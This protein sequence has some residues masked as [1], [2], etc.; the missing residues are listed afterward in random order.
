MLEQV[1]PKAKISKLYASEADGSTAVP[2][3]CFDP[4]EL[5]QPVDCSQGQLNLLTLKAAN[6]L[7]A[8]VRDLNLRT[9]FGISPQTRVVSVY[10]SGALDDAPSR[11][12]SDFG[13]TELLAHILDFTG[14]DLLLASRALSGAWKVQPQIDSIPVVRLSD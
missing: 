12:R 2:L 10:L 1:F 14:A 6:A 13:L 5:R 8:S 7:P 4:V 11:A 3:E 9:R